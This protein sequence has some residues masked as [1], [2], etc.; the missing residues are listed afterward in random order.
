[1]HK[2][3]ILAF[4]AILALTFPEAA[5]KVMSLLTVLGGL[6]E[7]EEKLIKARTGKERE[8]AKAR[9]IR[10]GRK[11]KLIPHQQREARL[12][13]GSGVVRSGPWRGL[14]TAGAKARVGVADRLA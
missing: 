11:P 1:L 7:F 2:P 10:M 5:Q 4:M 13:L 6:A 9:G 12:L 14:R 8:R 3:M